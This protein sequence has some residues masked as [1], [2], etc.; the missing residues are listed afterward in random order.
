MLIL[1][2][3]AALSS[4]ETQCEYNMSATAQDYQDVID[5]K[6][7][8][9]VMFSRQGCPHCEHAA[10]P[11]ENKAK[12]HKHIE[13]LKIDTQKDGNRNLVDELEIE[14]VPTFVFI[15]DGMIQDKT[16]GF[17][18]EESFANKVA[19]HVTQNSPEVVAA[20][21]SEHFSAEV[22][23][24]Q[25]PVEQA[26]IHH[27]GVFA[28]IQAFIIGLFNAIKHAIIGIFDWIKSLFSK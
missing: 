20:M 28:K 27:E 23:A 12:E 3:C 19:E 6:K 18:S 13:F 2:P 14:G 24:A 16:V 21:E 5:N 1:S 15:K 4:L 9:I 7:T 11:F 22:D 25:A 26:P 8:A 10:D 17:D